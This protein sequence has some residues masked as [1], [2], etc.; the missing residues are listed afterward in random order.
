MDRERLNSIIDEQAQRCV[1]CG[2]CRSVCPVFGE[3]LSEP[4]SARGKLSLLRALQDGERLDPRQVVERLEAC[5]LCGRCAEV[6]NAG[7]EPQL[8]IR[9]AR[10]L[11]RGREGLGSL[12]RLAYEQVLPRPALLGPALRIATRLAA[13]TG[14]GP[15]EGSG[16]F[17]RLSR[18]A[19]M[20]GRALPRVSGEFFI[21]QPS[22]PRA[23]GERRGKAVLFCGCVHNYVEPEVSHAT[24]RMVAA[25]GYDVS[26]P[27]DQ[28]CCGLAAHGAGDAPAA[29]RMARRNIDALLRDDPDWIVTNCG[30]CGAMLKHGLPELFEHDDP[31]RERAEKLASKVIDVLDLVD[32][33]ARP[34][35][36]RRIEPEGGGKVTYHDSC[37]LRL[38]MQV[39]DQPRRLLRSALGENFVEMP[40]AQ[41]CCGSGGAFS[42]HC[43]QLSRAILER[44]LD[45]VRRSGAQ[46]VAAACGGCLLQL[47]DMAL[48]IPGLRVE[49]PLYWLEPTEQSD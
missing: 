27:T 40:G 25:L 22:Q 23:R 34:G 45:G 28:C 2:K 43:P 11:L 6:C 44:K 3:A 4:L 30:S 21:E 12:W 32:R 20:E 17:Y 5:L 15:D 39:R 24:A 1:R 18:P 29:Q 38:E 42:L 36:I 13:L 46:S 35:L 9:A 26:V 37:H 14:S 16:I 31:Q 8:A 10:E 47:R 49:H 33:E 19:A 41:L 7:V 48:K